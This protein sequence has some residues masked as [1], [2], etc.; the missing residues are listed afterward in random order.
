M[1]AA[2]LRDAVD[3]NASVGYLLPLAASVANGYWI[4][5]EADVAADSRHVLA[6]YVGPDLVGSVQWAPCGKPNQPHRADVQ[7]LLVLRS[8]RGLGVASALMRALEND[9]SRAGRVLLVLD[10]RT[11]STADHCYRHWGWMDAGTI[12]DYA[13]DPDRTPAACTFFYKRLDTTGAHCDEYARTGS[14]TDG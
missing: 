10:T 9:A 2:L 3:D 12:P 6:A 11:G 14:R 5:I 8:A 4:A 13:L 1:L 7:K